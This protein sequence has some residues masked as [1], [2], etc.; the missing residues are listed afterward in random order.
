[1]RPVGWWKVRRLDK[2]RRLAL[3]A[4]DVYERGDH[5]TYPVASTDTK[6]V[7]HEEILELSGARFVP[8]QT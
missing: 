5:R 6:P 2:K 1:M 8:F 3:P 7:D 4:I